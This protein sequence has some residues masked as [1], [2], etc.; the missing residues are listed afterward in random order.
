MTFNLGLH[1]TGPNAVEFII[2]HAEVSIAF[3]QEKK[4]ASV[5][6]SSLSTFF[7]LLQDGLSQTFNLIVLLLQFTLFS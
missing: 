3:V 1:L 4:I 5:C 2:N 6:F 7:L